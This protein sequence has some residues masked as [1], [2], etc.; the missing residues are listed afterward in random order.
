M[1]RIEMRVFLR[2][3]ISRRQPRAC[4]FLFSVLMSLAGIST[5]LTLAPLQSFAQDSSSLSTLR[6][7]SQLVVLDVVVTDAKGN[8]VTN[9]DRSDFFIYQNGTEQGIRDFDTP[10]KMSSIPEKA[11]KD[12]YG[13]DDWGN[14]SLTMLVIDAM[15]TP[16]EENSVFKERSRPLPESAACVTK[17]TYDHTVGQ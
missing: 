12:K 3:S 16:F 15:N 11:P 6:V 7:Q 5:F 10:K 1:N 14:A 2:S 8:V 9:L 17:T 13:R 4:L